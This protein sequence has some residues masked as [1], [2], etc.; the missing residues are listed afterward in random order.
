M[1]G[2]F[3]NAWCCSLVW[4]LQLHVCEVMVCWRDLTAVDGAVACMLGGI[5]CRVQAL[6][7]AGAPPLHDCTSVCSVYKLQVAG[8]DLWW[9][10]AQQYSASLQQMWFHWTAVST[11]VL[12]AWPA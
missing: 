6:D 2:V 3:V 1:A 11:D 9:R 8:A 4:W 7:R 10:S 5:G 12:A